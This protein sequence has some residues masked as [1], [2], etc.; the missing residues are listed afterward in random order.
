MASSDWE[1]SDAPSE[2]A[3]EPDYGR[4]LR[5]FTREF[6]RERRIINRL[7]L[8]IGG[9]GLVIVSFCVWIVTSIHNVELSSAR[10]EEKLA[11]ISKEVSRISDDLKSLTNEVKS[12]RDKREKL[13]TSFT[14]LD[15]I[16]ERLDRVVPTPTP[17]PRS[18]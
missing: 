18:R 15:T 2:S 4:L 17:G 13:N 6:E 3:K 5:N 10:T 14:K 1:A 7:F 12:E 8:A 9:V 16:V 11:N